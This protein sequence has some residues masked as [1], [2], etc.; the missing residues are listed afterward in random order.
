MLDL[1]ETK[2]RV[3][4]SSRSIVTVSVKLRDAYEEIEKQR[5]DLTDIKRRNSDLESLLNQLL[6]TLEKQLSE[7][8]LEKYQGSPLDDLSQALGDA[9]ESPEPDEQA[10]RKYPATDKDD[11][12]PRFRKA[13]TS[14]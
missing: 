9:I 6:D 1:A 4:K 13:V 14:T 10:D 7:F 12:L 3:E 11:D 2:R 5:Q 8:L